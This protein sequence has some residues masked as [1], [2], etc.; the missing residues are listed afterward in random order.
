MDIILNVNIFYVPEF[1]GVIKTND[2]IVLPT[3]LLMNKMDGFQI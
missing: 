3:I 2:M 1:S